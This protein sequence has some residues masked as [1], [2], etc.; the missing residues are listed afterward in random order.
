MVVTTKPI[1]TGFKFLL[2]SSNGSTPQI[3]AAG[4]N[5]Q[6]TN[7]PPPTQIAAICPNAVNVAAPAPIAVPKM[8]ATDPA[9]EMPEKPE[10]SNPVIAPTAVRVI[11]LSV[12]NHQ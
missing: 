4:I 7:V 9:S 1:V 8:F 12:K 10:P 3:A 6:G 5:A 11:E 2:A